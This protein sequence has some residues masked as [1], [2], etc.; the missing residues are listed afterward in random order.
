MKPRPTRV[1]HVIQCLGGGGASRS[2]VST[3]RWSAALGPCEPTVISLLPAE[4]IGRELATASGI[5]LIDGPDPATRRGLLADADIVLLHFWNCPELYRF[6]ELPMP[7]VRLLIWFHVAGDNPPQ[8]ILPE[9]VEMADHAL[10]SCE[11]TLRLD[12]FRAQT[13][14]RTGMILDS[15]DFRRLSGM[16]RRPHRHF[17]VGYVGTVDFVKMHP[18]YVPMSAAIDI[19]DVRFLVCGNG[20]AEPELRRQAE[21]LDAAERFRFLG[22][23]EDLVPILE[24]MDVFG[25]PLCEDNYSTA[26]LI[27]Q[28][29]MYA[30]IPPVVFAHGGAQGTVEHERTG[31]VVTN[32]AEYQAAIEHL[33]HDP[34]ERERIGAN[35]RS[36]ARE[37]LGA[38]NAAPQFNRLFDDLIA[39]PKTPRRL[40]VAGSEGAGS[41]SPH[42][43]ADRFVRSLGASGIDFRHSRTAPDPATEFK[44]D[45]AIAHASPV[46]AGASSGGILHYRDA[47]PRDAFLRL[48]A[49]LVLWG[50]GENASAL[51]E[52]RRA[53]DLGLGH[54]RLHWY[55]KLI[56]GRLGAHK[57]AAQASRLVDEDTLSR[58]ASENLLHSFEQ[59][60]KRREAG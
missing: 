40:V 35:A 44:A 38:E 3:A 7:P 13:R 9:V 31:L 57:L 59:L 21:A 24:T 33:Y 37:N 25:Y 41:S 58:I 56:A 39:L 6:L 55:T 20:R 42:T 15:A 14:T 12:A 47:Y 8:V 22:Y 10:A 23:R 45:L 32:E 49:G 36:H 26:E 29:V 17:N 30:G 52:I 51:L 46:L 48:W 28:E 1:V 4:A 43:G 50:R 16:R 2:L 54:W 11:Y 27:L 19:P 34:Q 53:Q 60:G 5:R 18:A